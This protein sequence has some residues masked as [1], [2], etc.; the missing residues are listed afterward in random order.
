VRYLAALALS[1]W[2]FI[3]LGASAWAQTPP[4]P[5]PTPGQVP[6]SPDDLAALTA[7]RGLT[8]LSDLGFGDQRATGT[9]S[10]QEFFFPGPGDFA[11]GENST[12]TIELS[13]SNL[14]VPDRSTVSVIL[15]DRPLRA[16]YLD[17]SNTS[18]ARYDIRVPKDVI[19]K[20]FNLLRLEYAMTLGQEC[21]DPN[22]PALF[23]VLLAKSQLALDF[24]TSPP[25]PVL[26]SP[27]LS[28]YPYPFYRAG[29]P[30]VAPV[31][32]V[33]P[34]EP[35]NAELTAAYRIATDMASRV[36]FDLATLRI[37]QLRNLSTAERAESQ[38]IMIGAPAR[39]PL[40]RDVLAS[41]TVNAAADNSLRRADA[42]VAADHG[43]IVLAASPWNRSLR[44]LAITGQTDQA[45]A[46]DVDAL[47][48][49]EPAAL[50]AGP[51]T[52][53]TD[54]V[55]V[56]QSTAQFLTEFNFAQAGFA[57]RNITSVDAFNLAFTAPHAAAGADGQIDLIISTPEGLDRRRS[58][59]VV[60]LNGQQVQTVEL[61]DSQT[62]RASYRVHLPG[63][64]LRIGPNTLR[65]RTS[66]YTQDTNAYGR[67]GQLAF[68]RVWAIVHEDSAISLPETPD[69]GT[70]GI[71]TS[72][73]SLPFPFA[74]LSGLQ[75]TTFVVDPGSPAALRGGMLSAI[76][77]GRRAGARTRFDVQQAS[78]ATAASVGDR[79]VV[80]V[81]IP[82]SAPL[83]P[84][85]ER[86]LPLVFGPEGS[87]ALVTDDDKLTEIL[88]S[89]RVGALQV[90]PVPWA[91]GRRLLS[92]SG[93]DDQS[94]S[95]VTDG[96]TARP[97][98]GNVALMQ[99]PTDVSTFSL[100]RL[101]NEELE[102]EL[103]DR[104]TRRESLIS[105]LAAYA[106]IGGGAAFMLIAWALRDRLRGR[107]RR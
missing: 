42:P 28:A 18:G 19:K 102:G 6:G 68:E 107:L 61:K 95:W 29:Y 93:S 83:R 64:A 27:N 69:D 87:R 91:P 81:G 14:I 16:I 48:N 26:D 8:R 23:A 1:M 15:N 49:P 85:V 60:E 70:A 92:V 17:Q 33:L 40:V 66:L 5:T 7:L 41:S 44:A 99:S 9:R 57:D 11:L 72:L 55:R 96:L 101:T 98:E 32:I 103:R 45:L 10:Q 84:E 71:S 65:F 104:F 21:E 67:C 78:S 37:R 100:E 54:A 43:V 74:G 51:E 56:E 31:T 94:L 58:N 77:L 97:F 75:D 35:S 24:A 106:L 13:H 39:L 89:S 90:A 22:N 30:L 38:L 63:D 105:Q 62:R 50:L 73:A 86:V 25:V 76:A 80:L 20:D 12:L 46:R 79:H 82:P 3:S 88:D 34:D 4:T 2:L 52:I 59:I 47:T 36:S 53:L